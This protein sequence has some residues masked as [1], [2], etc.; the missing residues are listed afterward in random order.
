MESINRLQLE[1]G[2]IGPKL[3]LAFSVKQA[4]RA[5]SRPGGPPTR[6]QG[7]TIFCLCH[8]CSLYS[9]VSLWASNNAASNK[10]ASTNTEWLALWETKGVSIGDEEPL[11]HTSGF[12]GINL[13]QWNALVS[14]IIKPTQQLCD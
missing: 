3:V 6:S 10:A 8:I 1:G 12:N 7:P 13:D 4:K 14:T 2:P 5:Q 9:S 11:H